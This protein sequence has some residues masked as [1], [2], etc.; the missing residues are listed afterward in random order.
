MTDKV[1]KWDEQL[2]QFAT[3][4]VAALPQASV[5]VLSVK[6]GGRLF[7]NDTEV[8]GSKLDAVVLDFI[9]E[10]QWF[11]HEYDPN[12]AAS[13]ACYAYGNDPATMKPHPAAPKPQCESCKDCP[14]NQFGSAPKG[15]GKA[16]KNV[17]K[18]AVVPAGALDN[19]DE[20]AAAEIAVMKVS[21]TSVGHFTSYATSLR[22][23]LKR[24]P[25]AMVTEI[26]GGPD[27]RN[28]TR[29][30][31]TAVSAIEDGDCIAAIIEKRKTVKLDTAYPV[32]EEEPAPA[33]TART[34]N[35]FSGS[36]KLGRR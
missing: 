5:N 3:E 19:L 23:Q 35:R 33:Q 8:P 20:F 11:E 14:L 30:D 2:A 31:F 1:N 13:P 15:K 12:K 29:S 28:Q 6:T 10:N 36:S 16:C 9:R 17:L 25:F 32:F 21:V 26:K 24:P 4:A 27:Q 34:T 18:L 22:D 7:Y